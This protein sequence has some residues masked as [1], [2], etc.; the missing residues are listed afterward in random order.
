MEQLQRVIYSLEREKDISRYE[1]VGEKEQKK[2]EEK[3][4]KREGLFHRW[5]DRIVTIEGQNYPETYGIV[6][7]DETGEIKD[8]VPKRITF[9]KHLY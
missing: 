6:Q 5:G 7:D 3:Q 1:V 9:V 2:L 8:V 4:K